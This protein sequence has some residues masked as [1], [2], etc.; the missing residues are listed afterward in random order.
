MKTEG[1]TFSRSCLLYVSSCCVSVSLSR[2]GL[3]VRKKKTTARLVQRPLLSLSLSSI[4]A[5]AEATAQVQKQ[6]DDG[7]EKLVSDNEQTNDRSVHALPRRHQNK[8]RVEGEREGGRE[9]WVGGALGFF[10]FF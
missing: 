4:A 5:A 7:P 1:L 3:F 10:F 8:T 9:G 6:D 2:E